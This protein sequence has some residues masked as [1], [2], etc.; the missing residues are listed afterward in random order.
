[1]TEVQLPPA[2]V[3]GGSYNSVSV[4]RALGRQGIPV[5]ALGDGAGG[6]LVQHSK[7]LARYRSVTS[8]STATDE[9]LEWLQTGPR[10][11][12]L[13]P[14]SDGA[15]EFMAKH[16]QELVDLGYHPAAGADDVTLA[17]L[18]KERTYELARSVGVPA[19]RTASV[20]T[21]EELREA[22]AGMDFPCALKPRHSHLFARAFDA[23]A[24]IA[25]D[26]AELEVAFRATNEHGLEMIVTEII[27][28]DDSRYCS[29][30]SYLDDDGTPLFHFTKRKPRQ[31]PPGF[32]LGTYH[33]TEWVPDAAELGLRFF[34]GIG[35]RGIGNVEFK[36]DIRDGQLKIIECNPRFTAADKLVQRAG[37]DMAT[38]SYRRALGLQA[39]APT[40]FRSGLRQWH[41]MEDLYA[42]RAY[43][44]QGKLGTLAW[45]STLVRPVG[46]PMFDLGDLQPSL[47]YGRAF[48]R[49]IIRSTGRRLRAQLLRR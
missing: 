42:Y 24:L 5:H 9:W 32:G 10:G 34:T 45:L 22:A 25:E 13:L 44:A 15:L 46:L 23:K 40:S 27:P 17:M 29:Y 6:S 39:Q 48:A 35:L 31:N 1:V 38:M 2:V 30:Y 49:R 37:I 33:L 4:T 28:G 47:V 8:S 21:M 36:R 19:P 16:R 12:V 26:A 11:A 20:T 14:C 41:P 7:Y 43:R 3:L 18:D